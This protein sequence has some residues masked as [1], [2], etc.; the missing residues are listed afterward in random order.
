MAGS[1]THSLFGVRDLGPAVPVRAAAVPERRITSLDRIF[2][3]GSFALLI[4]LNVALQGLK[5]GPLPIRGLLAA[6]LLAAVA[7]IYSQAT[8]RALDRHMPVL[9]VA[10]A[11]AL[12]GT[13]VSLVGDVGTAV[14]AKALI[15][16]HVQVVVTLLVGTVLAELCGSRAAVLAIVL[17]V[18]LSAALAVLQAVNLDAAWQAREWLANV[19]H[20]PR[21]VFDV[22]ERMRPPGLS[23]SPVQLSTQLCLAFAAFA[24]IRDQYLKSQPQPLSADP[25]VLVALAALVAVAALSGTRSPIMG[26]F[27][28]A[29]L[30]LMRRQGSWLPLML[31]IV[32][33]LIYVAWPMISAAVEGARPRVLRTEDQSALGRV[34]LLSFG[35]LLFVNNPLGY[36]LGFEPSAL[37][38]QYWHE[39]YNLPGA[40]NVRAFDLHNYVLSMLNTY[41]IGLLLIVPLAARL[42]YRS[43]AVLMFFIPYIVHIMFHNSGPFWNDMIIWFVVAAL[44]AMPVMRL[45]SAPAVPLMRARPQFRR[46]AVRT[47]RNSVR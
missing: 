44:S 30:Y 5:V 1:S 41:G 12:L 2:A 25:L 9:V 31:L 47:K 35:V 18:A 24:A 19:Q 33:A 22:N 4:F 26:G 10:G 39:I 46:P 8:A 36:G 45:S 15:E 14:I 29:A 20:Q 42:L 7:L 37:W 3:F 43:R 32:A 28:F 13:F 21:D 11:L 17:A 34:S 40:A 27:L 16:V 38:T 23:Y 6:G